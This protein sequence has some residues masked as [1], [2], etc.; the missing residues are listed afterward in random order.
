M[1]W[2]ADA[3]VGA[4]HGFG[5]ALLDA[6]APIELRRR[7]LVGLAQLVPATQLFASGMA[8]LYDVGPRARDR[9]PADQSAHY[10]FRTGCDAIPMLLRWVF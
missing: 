7:A 1:T 4:A 3:D 10:D 8:S 5:R 9:A 2:L 6:R